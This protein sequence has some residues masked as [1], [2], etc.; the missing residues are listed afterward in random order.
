MNANF[1]GVSTWSATLAAR[2]A[3]HLFRTSGMKNYSI[4]AVLFSA[5]LGG[6]SI[7]PGKNSLE[8]LIAQHVAAMGGQAAMEAISTVEYSIQI[9]EPSFTVDG[10]YLADRQGR[11]R[12]DIYAD[13]KRVYT[14]A[15]DGKSA[16]QMQG[17]DVASASSADG[18]AALWR[19]TQFPGK[20]LG[21][22]EMAAREHKLEL[23]GDETIDGT[24]YRVVRLTY[25][26]GF[27]TYLYFN[28]GTFLIERQRDER[29]LHPDADPSTKWL[30]NRFEDYRPLAGVMRSWSS[31][32]FDV[33]TGATLQTS[34]V[35]SL[36]VNV[37][38]DPELFRFGTLPAD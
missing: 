38:I 3:T 12:I 15:H 31:C 11:M 21:L 8:E 37:P 32:Q 1:I 27:P 36:R 18:A 4:A 33:K 7:M 25:S 14:E 2:F 24:H 13:G 35:T 17:D 20:L 22:H 6:C 5:L 29:A 30:E 10:L 9:I 34:K 19:G 16:W 23:A 26:D 28:A